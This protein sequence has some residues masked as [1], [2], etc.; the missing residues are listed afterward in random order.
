MMSS[1][2]AN[3]G[4][5]L[6]R[7]KHLQSDQTET[8]LNRCLTTFDLT[9][10]GVGSTIGLGIYVLSGQVASST[11]GPA[12]VVS[13]FIAGVTSIFA[14]LCYAEF[15][16]LVPKAGSAYIYSYI[17]VGEFMA[18]VIGWNLVLENMIGAASLARG[19]SGY[20]DSLV[21]EAGWSFQDFFHRHMPM[22]IAYLSSEPDFLAFGI[23]VFVAI[24]MCL[25]VKKS[26]NLNSIFTILNLCVVVFL[27]IAG[28]L[29][30]DTHNWSLSYD[31][32]PHEV[33]NITHPKAKHGGNGGFLPFGVKGMMEGAATCFYAF[34]GFDHICSTSEEAKNPKKSVPRA[35][36]LALS[37]CF[38][39]YTG[40]AAIQTLIWPYWD[41]NVDAP[42]AYV[43]DKIDQ[44][45]AKWAV[46][47]GAVLGLSTTLI[48][49]LFTL[50]RIFYAMASDGL[51]YRFL[52]KVSAKT[53][54][55]VIA[56][57]LS[58]VMA[59]ALAAIFDVKQLADMISI[60]TLLAYSLVAN[61]V[62]IL[63][64]S[65]DATQE[66]ME[67]DLTRRKFTPEKLSES[68]FSRFFNLTSEDTPSKATKNTS[69]TIACASVVLV[70]FMDALTVY[71]Q[72]EI[73]KKNM[74]V[75]IP[76][77]LTIALLLTFLFALSR[78]PQSSERD[79]FQV[80]LVPFIPFASISFN[81]YLMMNLP[82]P[83]WIRFGVWM[84]IG[85]FIFF[86][87]GVFNSTGFMRE[88]EKLEHM[89]KRKTMILCFNRRQ[90]QPHS[91]LEESFEEHPPTVY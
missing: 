23:M 83:T 22:K 9:T 77:V 7:K 33:K 68:L 45:V 73:S 35:I 82:T 62:V 65:P 27:I 51:V 91:I 18:F 47:V 13:F 76:L 54:C 14:A 74:G 52:G 3:I 60:G 58:G 8:Q 37:I 38:M 5:S 26:T 72:D 29:K 10:L 32:V 75:I 69:I 21:K 90:E 57:L 40:V 84:V 12:I 30:V 36:L 79:S 34:I 64:Y 50:P 48:G 88:D 1:Y 31:E 67:R 89:Q 71:G 59:G 44:P 39:A 81:I 86:T 85:F 80:P 25:G 42:L 28:S 56:T 15:G 41:Q 46:S 55:P 87:Y 70:I 24:L 11:A 19:Y 2:F 63:R 78:Q 4:S 66:A 17:T 43:F 49:V 16:S 61:S 6:K 20:V 53:Q